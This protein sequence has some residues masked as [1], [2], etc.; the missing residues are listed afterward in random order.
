MTTLIW[1]NLF[2]PMAQFEIIQNALFNKV[3]P[4]YGTG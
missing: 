3:S 2:L 1:T 4:T